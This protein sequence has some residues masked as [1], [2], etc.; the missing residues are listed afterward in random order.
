M[1]SQLET[2]GW[3]QGESAIDEDD[4]HQLEFDGEIT[5]NHWNGPDPAGFIA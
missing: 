3:W 4:Y 5:G 2:Y 1:D